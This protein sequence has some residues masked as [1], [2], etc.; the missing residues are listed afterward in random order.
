MNYVV[1]LI[2]QVSNNQVFMVLYVTN[3]NKTITF[4]TFAI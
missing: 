1:F 4:V 3:G 2:K